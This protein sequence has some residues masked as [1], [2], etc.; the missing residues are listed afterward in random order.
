VYV[1]FHIGREEKR[2][3]RLKL[4]CLYV[5]YIYNYFLYCY[6]AVI[7][8]LRSRFQS[9]TAQRQSLQNKDSSP[10]ETSPLPEKGSIDVTFTETSSLQTALSLLTATPVLVFAVH[11]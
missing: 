2:R 9:M 5:L 1:G 6:T 11:M 10:A 3:M 8:E 7:T 4:V